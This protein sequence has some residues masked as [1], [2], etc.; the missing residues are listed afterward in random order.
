VVLFYNI[1]PWRKMLEISK[2]NIFKNKV[3]DEEKAEIQADDSCHGRILI[4]VNACDCL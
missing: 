1:G 4:I 2:K 3:G